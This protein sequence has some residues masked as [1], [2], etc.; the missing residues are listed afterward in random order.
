M[1]PESRDAVWEYAAIL[2]SA[3]AWI[4]IGLQIRHE[5]VSAL[6]ST[7]SPAYALG[8]FGIMVFW[9]LYGIRFRRLAV[10]I[11]N[12]VAAV[13]QAILILAAFCK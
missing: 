8:F 4:F 7:L 9:T 2:A 10:W 12:S 5:L 11:G 6:P 13:L 1:Q 3:L